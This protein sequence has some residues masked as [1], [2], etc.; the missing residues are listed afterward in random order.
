MAEWQPFSNDT[1]RTIE[2]PQTAAFAEV[3]LAHYLS[4]L[5]DKD[6]NLLLFF[7]I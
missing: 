5:V 2:T 1:H 3:Q 4:A 7:S 6:A